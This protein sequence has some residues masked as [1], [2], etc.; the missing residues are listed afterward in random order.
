MK[1]LA[2]EINDLATACAGA[3]ANQGLDS[4]LSGINACLPEMEFQPVMT[5][6]GWY[7]LGG[8]IDA[9]YER[10]SDNIRQWLEQ[11]AED[12]LETFVEDQRSRGLIATRLQGQTHYLTAEIGES[13]EDYIQLEVEELQE[14]TDR[15]LLPYDWMP[16]D[17][18]ELLDPL[19]RE[20]LVAE[21]VGPPRYIF[22]RIQAVSELL[23]SAAGR[24]SSLK[25]FMYDWTASSAG[26]TGRFSR[27]WVLALRDTEGSDG[28]MYLSAKPIAAGVQ[29]ECDL[30]PYSGSRGEA[31]LDETRCFDHAA[32]YPF[33]WFFAMLTSRKVPFELGEA[34]LADLAVDFDYLPPRD[35]LILSAWVNKRYA[36]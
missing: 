32:G 2:L 27:H 26:K 34:V 23:E 6:S 25:R 36:V 15:V 10:V 16:D 28:D 17:L 5:R 29:T 22:R 24:L 9:D 21:P 4:L 7:R 30:S 12:D 13:P 20:Q 1:D 31:L 11:E 3:D 33:A 35:T 14:V 18:E 19:K 8:V